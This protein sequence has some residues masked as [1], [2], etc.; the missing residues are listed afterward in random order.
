MEVSAALSA[1]VTAGS[2]A[3]ALAAA[4]GDDSGGGDAIC[5]IGDRTPTSGV[6]AGI[7]M[8]YRHCRP[9]AAAGAVAELGYQAEYNLM[10]EGSTLTEANGR[11]FGTCELM[12]AV[13][14]SATMLLNPTGGDLVG[15]TGVDSCASLCDESVAAV[16]CDTGTTTAPL[17][18][19]PST[20]LVCVLLCSVR[21]RFGG[22]ASIGAPV[23]SELTASLEWMRAG[24]RPARTG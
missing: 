16:N 21:C 1:A 18:L 8:P 14:C 22:D 15:N 4:G 3:E 20:V 17:A 10:L 9:N 13:E 12:A 19:P 11:P 24:A 5:Y 23:N 2:A 6:C 7:T